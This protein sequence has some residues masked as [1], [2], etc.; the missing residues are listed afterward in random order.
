[1]MKIIT[2][3]VYYCDFCKKKGLSKGHM[4]KHE[5]HC[6][7]NP[8]RICRICDGIDIA[9]LIGKYH[10]RFTI[11][12]QESSL[13]ILGEFETVEWIGEPVTHGMILDDVDGCPACGLAVVRASGLLD[14]S[15]DF[16]FDYHEAHKQWWVD[17]NEEYHRQEE[18]YYY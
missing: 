8:N 12:K 15:S 1:M 4:I 18:N 14:A 16:H 2:K 13:P 10:G 9:P 5:N 6:T 3:P 11:K 17:R 7:G